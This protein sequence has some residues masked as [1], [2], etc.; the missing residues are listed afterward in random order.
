MC[1]ASYINAGD[2]PAERDSQNKEITVFPMFGQPYTVKARRRKAATVEGS[3]ALEDLFGT[4]PPDR[5][6]R[7]ART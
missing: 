2:V 4:P 7:A 6:N 5:F 1:E 3:E